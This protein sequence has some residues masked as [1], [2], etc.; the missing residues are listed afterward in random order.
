MKLLPEKYK[1]YQKFILMVLKYR[2][3]N[4][5]SSLS[6]QIADPHAQ[7][8]KMNDGASYTSPQEFLKDL[9]D[10]GPTYVKIGQTLSTRPDLIPE[11]YLEALA[12]LQE[13]VKSVSFSKIKKIIEE[14]LEDP[15]DLIFPKFEQKPLASASIGQVHLAQLPSGETVVVKVQRPGIREAFKEDLDAL[16]N[17]AELAVKNLKTAQKYGIDDIIEEM[18]HI[19]FAEL[20]YIRE[21][22]NLVALSQNLQEY[23]HLV[24][25]L[26]IEGYCTAKVL[27]MEY[28]EGIKITDTDERRLSE[29]DFEPMVDDL[30][31]GYLKQILLDG[32]AHA[33]PHP[34]NIY[35]TPD[36]RI[37]LLDLGMTAKFGPVLQDHILKLLFHLIS[38]E[39]EK[40]AQTL[41]DISTY[42]ETADLPSFYRQIN[43]MVLETQ[44]QTAE[45]MQTGKLIIYMNR[46]AA[47]N[48]IK[49][50]VELNILGKILINLDQIIALLTPE[51]RF[52]DKMKAFLKK[53]V[54][55]KLRQETEPENYFTQVIEL[56]K[57]IKNF[58]EWFNRISQNLAEN[59]F[60][61][62][63]NAIDEQRFTDAFQKVANR[64]S[65]GLII[66][67]LLIGS[68][69]MM[70][71][72]M[73]Y[74]IMG[75]P[76]LAMV[77][78]LAAA[79]FGLWLVYKM[80]RNDEDF[81][82]K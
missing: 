3:S 15:I 30:V 10:M 45:N 47:E 37:A 56:R 25:P 16:Q 64:I 17:M 12:T 78:F 43:R 62:K 52:M 22:R 57:L 20:D 13:E 42:D 55:K 27:T 60:E 11:P 74:S 26:P 80:V 14:E 54:L 38:H 81:K 51:Y 73:A 59:S 19:L 70:Q 5:V 44:N 71:I 7:D 31:E 32:L 69:F 79:F 28:L 8:P 29:T 53:I 77:F 41:L 9:K 40:V 33:D 6:E 35:L 63:V 23:P 66:A 36:N 50:A 24:V 61:V 46:I 49:I 34:G 65:L 2:N 68:A 58:P 21:A 1:V 4:L 76:A 75:Y 18:R 72:P 82:K 39:G 67:G 48:G